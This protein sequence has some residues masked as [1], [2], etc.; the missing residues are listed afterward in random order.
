MCIRWFYD[1]NSGNL[2][3][4]FLCKSETYYE[5]E[6]KISTWKICN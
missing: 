5:I 3:C 2:Y 4:S 1:I 6:M